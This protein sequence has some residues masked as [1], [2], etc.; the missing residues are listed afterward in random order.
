M[1]IDAQAVSEICLSSIK[2]S[3]S[4]L[5]LAPSAA[6]TGGFHFEIFGRVQKVS[7]RE[8]T[9]RKAK[10]LQLVGW[11]KNTP[12]NTVVG[13]AFGTSSSLEAFQDWLQNTGSPSSIIEKAEFT[14]QVEGTGVE[15]AMSCLGL[16]LDSGLNHQHSWAY[17][18]HK[19]SL[20]IRVLVMLFLLY[21]ILTKLNERKREPQNGALL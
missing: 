5:V 11:V 14:Q 12:Q 16:S 13:V 3:S 19:A 9:R 1:S 21:A 15:E 7:F 6:R 10:Q 4:D 8:Y 20:L 2:G 18:Q 17:V